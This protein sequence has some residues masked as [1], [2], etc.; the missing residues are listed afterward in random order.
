MSDRGPDSVELPGPPEPL[1][2]Y[3]SVTIIRGGVMGVSTAFHLARAGAGSVLV[4]EQNLLGWLLGEAVGWG[5]GN[6]R[7]SR[8]PCVGAT[9]SRSL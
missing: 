3:A 9:Q 7:G 6:V 2:S 1:P 5:E 8:Q 4:I